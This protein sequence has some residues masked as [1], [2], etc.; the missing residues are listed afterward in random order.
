MV[1]TLKK[2]LKIT[3]VLLFLVALVNT[4]TAAQ[5]D[6]LYYSDKMV[7]NGTF[8][9]TVIQNNNTNEAVDVYSILDVGSNFTVQLK[10]DL[11]PGPITEDELNSIYATIEVDGEKYTGSGFP[12]FWHIIKSEEGVN[13]TIREE[14]EAETELFN[15]S[16]AGSNFLVNFTV[17]DIFTVGSTNY[18]LFVELEIDP[19]DGLTKRYYDELM[20]GTVI[21]NT[22]EMV[23]ADYVV[24]APADTLWI[25]TGLVTV[26]AIVW[27]IKRKRK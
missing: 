19:L 17:S 22:Y 5:E 18:T 20:N 10:D 27:F 2:M 7:K 23:Y 26:S 12:L 9:W 4:T 14:F 15:V 16:D 21:E 13:T 11:Y 8:T 6:G 1:A 3:F 25:I 24:S